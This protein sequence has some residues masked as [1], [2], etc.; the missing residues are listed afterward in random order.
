MKLRFKPFTYIDEKGERERFIRGALM[1]EADAFD[2][3]MNV[4]IKRT[5]M[6]ISLQVSQAIPPL[7]TGENRISKSAI[8]LKTNIKICTSLL[9]EETAG[10]LDIF[11]TETKKQKRK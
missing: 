3:E 7:N 11:Y 4:L 1:K 10:L 6:M 5:K 2:N 8:I 9:L